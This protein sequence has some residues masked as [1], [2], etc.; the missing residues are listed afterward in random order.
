[1][2]LGYMTVKVFLLQ[3]KKIMQPLQDSPSG[4]LISYVNSANTL[5][6]DQKIWL[7]FQLCVF[8]LKIV[9]IMK[10]SYFCF[11][12]IRLD[13]FGTKTTGDA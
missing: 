7:Y 4:P 1:M 2:H 5:F 12:N 13:F 10:L 8:T 9:R 11:C 6:N 3:H